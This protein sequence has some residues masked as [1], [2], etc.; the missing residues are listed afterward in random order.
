MGYA[1][2]I[3]VTLVL[4][5]IVVARLIADKQI[6][7]LGLQHK[8]EELDEQTKKADEAVKSYAEMR[9]DFKRKYGKPSGGSSTGD[10]RSS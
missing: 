8:K 9:D 7:E 1:V 5:A 3:G 10:D 2:I 6:T 4:I